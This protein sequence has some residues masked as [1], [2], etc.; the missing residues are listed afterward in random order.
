MI[1]LYYFSLLVLV[2]TLIY[3]S[4]LDLKTRT[5][6]FE[7][8]YPLIAIGSLTTLFYLLQ[9]QLT[10]L[11]EVTIVVTVIVF[12]IC[13]LFKLYGGAD[14]WCLIFITIFGISIPFTP[15][16]NN[17]FIGIGVSTYI[18]AIIFLW[19]SYPIIK[20]I[21]KKDNYKLPFIIYITGG[22]MIALIFGN[23]NEYIIG[24][25]L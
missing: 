5:I 14:A 24:A 16:W 12:Y 9:N 22:F 20:Y 6:Q 2:G 15:L 4:Y 17:S 10:L 1:L 11:Q 19:L 3:T 23:I 21:F 25:I 18:N 13:G 8:W 7:N